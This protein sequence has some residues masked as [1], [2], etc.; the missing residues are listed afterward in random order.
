MAEANKNALAI[1]QQELQAPKG[2]YNSFGKYK[3]R[4][5]E[6]I[7]KAVKPLLEKTNTT[8]T[9]TDTLEQIGERY[10]VKAEAQLNDEDLQT[11]A[12]TVGYAREEE[13]KKGMDGSQITGSSS[14]YA[15]KYAL[16]GLFAIDDGIDSDTTN[17]HEDKPK[18]A[19]TSK[20]KTTTGN[21]RID[22]KEVNEKIDSATSVEE[23]RQIYASVPKPLQQYFKDRCKKAVAKL[24]QELA[25]L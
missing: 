12:R 13:D 23:I 1:I 20:A 18:R 2:Q 24:E 14:S 21:E 25:S 19:T 5:C 9:L 8:L 6:D 10:Y 3:Y 7:L 4:S 15:R 22:F 11:I 16:C 17:T